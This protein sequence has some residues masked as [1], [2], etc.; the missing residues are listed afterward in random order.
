MFGSTTFEPSALYTRS[1]PRSAIG[2][3]SGTRIDTMLLF[4]SFI[5]VD[6]ILCNSARARPI[7]PRVHS[8]NCDVVEK[9]FDFA[10]FYTL[11]SWRMFDVELVSQGVWLAHRCNAVAP[12]VALVV[13]ILD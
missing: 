5:G 1:D 11:R 4:V 12:F 13:S 8:G 10:R 6:I 3:V 9:T 2:A 7:S